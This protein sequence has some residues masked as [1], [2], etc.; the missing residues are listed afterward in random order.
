MEDKEGNVAVKG[1][2]GMKGQAI[3]EEKKESNILEAKLRLLALH[4]RLLGPLLA[5]LP[6]QEV[7]LIDPLHPNDP[8]SQHLRLHITPQL[9]CSLLRSLK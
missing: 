8:T 7:R 9:T 4:S 2:G 3:V 6:D 5:G 1:G